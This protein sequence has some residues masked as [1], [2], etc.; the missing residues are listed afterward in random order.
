MILAQHRVL[1]RRGPARTSAARPSMGLTRFDD[2]SRTT[3]SRLR[4][5]WPRHQHD[6]DRHET[7][8]KQAPFDIRAISNDA[9]V[10]KNLLSGMTSG[11]RYRRSLLP[12]ERGCL[13]AP[14]SLRLTVDGYAVSR[15]SYKRVLFTAPTFAEAAPPAAFEP[16]RFHDYEPPTSDRRRQRQRLQVFARDNVA[17]AR[18]L[19]ARW[20]RR[21][22][23]AL[24]RPRCPRALPR[25]P[26][27]DH[28]RGYP[29]RSAWGSAFR[30]GRVEFSP[31]AADLG[32]QGG[33]PCGEGTRLRRRCSSARGAPHPGCSSRRSWGSPTE[34]TP[35]SP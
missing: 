32:P 28:R 14:C 25:D 34:S 22:R 18:I 7:P 16:H 15:R 24:V 35:T 9:S 4:A 29:R 30:R 10:K 12:P 20:R 26:L 1:L 31:S 23:A 11:D 21:G 6:L 27:P 33:L 5:V 19:Y 8:A 2:E 13:T 3:Y 17:F